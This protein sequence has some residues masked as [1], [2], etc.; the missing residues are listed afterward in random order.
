MFE[1]DGLNNSHVGYSAPCN[2]GGEVG[3]TVS[4]CRGGTLIAAWG[5]GATVSPMYINLDLI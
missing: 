1:C 3:D 4:Q 2:S 5:I